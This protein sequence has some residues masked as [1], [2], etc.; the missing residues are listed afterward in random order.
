MARTSKNRLRVIRG[1]AWLALVAPLAW[2]AL[3]VL[4]DHLGANP[5]E[6]IILWSGVSTLVLLMLTLAVTPLRRLTGWNEV[7]RVRRF[8]GL[9]AFGYLC[10]HFLSYVGLDQFFAFD[11]ILAD[12]AKRPFITVGFAAFL[13]LIPLAVTSTKGWIRRLGRRWQR[14]H[15]LVYVATALGVL[16]YYWK[17]KAD[18]RWPL[19]FAI[20][21]VVL[22]AARVRARRSAEKRRSTPGATPVVEHA[23]APADAD[24]RR[25]PVEA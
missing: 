13:L 1:A 17:V 15:Q 5:I 2:L 14:L 22:L 12:I 3:R 25:T 9:T 8:L 7:V 4:H 10:L 6:A 20:V 19:V 21:L 18:T 24:L 11:F 23:A 16:H